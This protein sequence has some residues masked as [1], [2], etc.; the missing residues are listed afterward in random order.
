MNNRELRLNLLKLVER[1]R[2]NKHLENVEYI[3]ELKIKHIVFCLNSILQ[4][5]NIAEAYKFIAQL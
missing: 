1:Y 5:N 2:K 3:D 4:N